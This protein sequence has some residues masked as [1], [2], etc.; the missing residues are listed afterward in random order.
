MIK[1]LKCPKDLKHKEL[2]VIKLFEEGKIK[3][4]FKLAFEYGLAKIKI[5][6]KQQCDYCGRMI[7]IKKFD[8]HLCKDLKK[9]KMLMY[10]IPGLTKG[11]AHQIIYAGEDAEETQ[12][13]SN[14]VWDK[15]L[16][17]MKKRKLKFRKD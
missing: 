4:G 7:D 2:E 11:D 6:R 10:Q 15:M 16:E 5:E 12:I 9:V 1:R 17:I 13:P 14:L 3:E 8:K